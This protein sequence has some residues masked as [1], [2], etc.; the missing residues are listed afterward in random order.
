MGDEVW[1]RTVQVV[2]NTPD[3]QPYAAR[4]VLARLEQSPCQETLV[5]LA[6]YILGEWGYLIA[7]QPG[8]SPLE[9]FHILHTRSHLSTW[10]TRALLLNTYVKWINVFPELREQ[11]LY[12]LR[13]YQHVLDTELQQRACEYVALA[14]APSETLLR[15]VCE[16]MPPYSQHAMQLLPHFAAPDATP[17][18]RRNR[19]RPVPSTAHPFAAASLEDPALLD[20]MPTALPDAEPPDVVTAADTSTLGDKSVDLLD[21]RSFDLQDNKEDGSEPAA[22]DG[23]SIR[24]GSSPEEGAV[25]LAPAMPHVSGGLTPDAAGGIGAGE[26]TASQSPLLDHP[27][28]G[29]R[30]QPVSMR[31][32]E[33]FQRWKMI[34][35]G[36]PRE[37]QD[38]F[39]ILLTADGSLDH[40][41]YRSVVQAAGFCILEQIDPRPETVVGTGVMN[42]DGGKVGCMLRL[43]PNE[44]VRL[45]RL[46]VRTTSGAV[47]RELL[48]HLSA[49]LAGPTEAGPPLPADLQGVGAGAARSGGTGLHA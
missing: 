24:R 39:P 5:K 17:L 37:V 23:L 22:L 35:Q 10:H 16:E 47:S 29:P 30:L 28:T 3:A 4:Q 43:E 32:D 19:V 13:R 18:N 6:A 46:T 15:D 8:A 49:R 38:V 33:F 11:L 7:D 45:C 34:G 40:G 26:R 2:A 25:P 21:L 20:S 9:Q 1:C 48:Q 27:E 12:V 42:T 44:R 31:P 36:E 41:R 14:E